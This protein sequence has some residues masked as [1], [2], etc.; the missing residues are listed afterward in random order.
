MAEPNSSKPRIMVFRPTWEE[1]KDFSKYIQHMESHGAH[2]AGLAKVIPP[3]EWVPR[4]SGYNLDDLNLTIPAPICQVVTGKQGLYQQINIQKKSMTVQQY[5]DLA[6]SDRYSTPRHFDYEDLERKYWKNITYVAPIYGADVSG[7][8]TD[9]DVDEWNINRLGTILDLVNEDYGISIEGVNT[10]YLYFGMW[11]TTFAWHTEDMDLYSINYL[12]FGAPKTWYSIPPEHGRRLERLANGFFPSS[13]QSCQ[14][15][16]RHKM[17]LISPQVLK[18]YSIPYNKITQEEGEIMITFPYGYHAGFNHGFN[19]AESTNFAAPRWVEYGKRATQCTCSKDMVKISMDT[20]VKRFQPEKYE[21]WLQGCDI[22]PHPEEPNRQVAAPHPM[23]QDIL[24]NKNNPELPSSFT[25]P[26]RSMAG[27]KSKSSFTEQQDFSMTDFPRDLQ[28]QLIEED[29]ASAEDIVPDEQQMEVLEDIW[30]KA[31]EIDVEDATM[32]DEGY[33]VGGHRKKRRSKD[34]KTPRKRTPKKKTKPVIPGIPFST[35]SA[36][37]EITASGLFAPCSSNQTK[38]VCGPIVAP[39]SGVRGVI[40]VNSSVKQEPSNSVD[41]DISNSFDRI[42]REATIEHERTLQVSERERMLNAKVKIFK[43]EPEKVKIET[44]SD[45]SAD[46]I[47]KMGV[48]VKH[49]AAIKKKPRKSTHPKNIKDMTVSSLDCGNF[50]KTVERM[51]TL[52]VQ[53]VTEPFIEHES[54]PTLDP[55]RANTERLLR[56]ISSGQYT[57]VPSHGDAQIRIKR[58]DAAQTITTPAVNTNVVQLVK[59]PQSNQLPSDNE[60]IISKYLNNP[61]KNNLHIVQ[62]SPAMVNQIKQKITEQIK[63]NAIHLHQ[64]VRPQVTQ[65]LNQQAPENRIIIGGTEKAVYMVDNKTLMYNL[66]KANQVVLP[67]T[68]QSS[69]SETNPVN[70]NKYYTINS[71][72]AATPITEAQD[73][74]Y[75]MTY[76]PISLEKDAEMSPVADWKQDLKK[77]PCGQKINIGEI[78]VTKLDKAQTSNETTRKPNVTRQ[79]A[80]KKHILVVNNND[81]KPKITKFNTER[82]LQKINEDMKYAGIKQKGAINGM[83]QENLLK[84]KTPVQINAGQELKMANECNYNSFLIK[85]NK[86]DSETKF[87]LLTVSNLKLDKE[88]NLETDLNEIHHKGKGC[89]LEYNEDTDKDNIEANCESKMEGATIRSGVKRYSSGKPVMDEDNINHDEADEK[90]KMEY[91]D[92]ACDNDDSF[93]TSKTSQS[94]NESFSSE[95]NSS[96]E[97][98]SFNNSMDTSKTSNSIVK[99]IQLNLAVFEVLNR[100][101]MD[102]NSELS[103]SEDSVDEDFLHNDNQY[104]FKGSASDL[105]NYTNMEGITCKL[106]NFLKSVPGEKIDRNAIKQYLEGTGL[107]LFKNDKG[108]WDVR[109]DE[110]YLSDS[111]EL[112]SAK[113]QKVNKINDLLKK[114]KTLTPYKAIVRLSDCML[115]VAKQ[116]KSRLLAQLQSQSDEDDEDDN[117]LLSE[118]EKKRVLEEVWARRNDG[119]FYRAVILEKYKECRCVVFI[120]SAGSIIIDVAVSDIRSI[121]DSEKAVMTGDRIILTRNNEQ[122]EGVLLKK[123]KHYLYKVK[124]QDGQIAVVKRSCVFTKDSSFAKKIA[125]KIR[126]KPT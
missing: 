104:L 1:F 9:P 108:L 99:T 29:M 39:I 119:A 85:Q 105:N 31:G 122:Q 82:T 3:Q 60:M 62:T 73:R 8:L 58:E 65:L 2:K 30:L 69:T 41:E 49:E 103:S 68:Q 112:N 10:A 95:T 115:N 17:T 48:E 6:N 79:P 5:R 86:T 21:K 97:N 110:L 7:S 102:D 90:V 101:I 66:P 70:Y 43:A 100:E 50:I 113:R 76:K 54:M 94:I 72:P 34:N 4:K 38:K 36:L 35:N 40:S 80:D 26:K 84:V 22:G 12:H 67:S 118:F 111:C 77:Q 71:V 64:T 107:I 93:V 24:C 46:F 61:Q 32:L 28:M 120:E 18:Q 83:D 114:V 19:C 87:N 51:P 27:R 109:S 91:S 98:K 106:L 96:L 16:L 57:I 23:P 47:S 74:F 123:T 52:K 124:Y 75:P 33:K 20:F 37:D 14:A 63:T 45:V 117:K 55:Q 121:N 25:L 53:T 81:I 44:F 88:N 89:L 59:A 15:F 42:I 11:K 13:Y 126:D 56:A 125:S 78:T 92:V 116:D